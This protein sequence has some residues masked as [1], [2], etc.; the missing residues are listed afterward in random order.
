MTE[1]KDTQVGTN[2]TMVS[3][4]SPD[5]INWTVYRMDYNDICE[6]SKFVLSFKLSSGLQEKTN[7]SATY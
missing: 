2:Y 6:Y 7:Y 1:F 5:F 3:Y 4:V